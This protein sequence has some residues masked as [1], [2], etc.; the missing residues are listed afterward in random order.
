MRNGKLKPEYLPKL[1]HINDLL[2]EIRHKAYEEAWK[3][4]A[5]LKNDL[6]LGKIYDYEIDLNLEF[7]GKNE[8]DL[9]KELSDC[10]KNIDEYMED[11]TEDYKYFASWPEHPMS[12]WPL[13]DWFHE[14]HDHCYTCD[15]FLPTWR[16]IAST[17]ICWEIIVRYQNRVDCT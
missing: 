5:G 2:K 4:E 1:K 15:N 13:C 8:A 14:L 17:V 12:E 16:Q 10:L 6:D 3:I 11:Y 7:Y 9:Y